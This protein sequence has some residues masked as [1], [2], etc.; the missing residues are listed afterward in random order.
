MI[1]VRLRVL[2]P[3]RWWASCSVHVVRRDPGDV[4]V[5]AGTAK[6]DALRPQ[7]AAL[8]L[9]LRQRAVGADDSLPGNSGVVAGREDVA[10]KAR[11]LRAEI[12]VGGHEA[13][14]DAPDAIEDQPRSRRAQLSRQATQMPA[15]AAGRAVAR[16]RS[17]A[18]R[19]SA[20]T[21]SAKASESPAS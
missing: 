5:D 9:P 15:S 10:G 14:R 18:V 3:C 2:I 21:A 4:H 13:G 17:P 12:A 1:T 20:R 6:R 19:S 7:Q 8:T 11:R 16:P